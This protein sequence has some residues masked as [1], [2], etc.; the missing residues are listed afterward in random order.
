ML[1]TAVQQLAAALRPSARPLSPSG[2]DR[3]EVV[4]HSD[5]VEP[6]SRA[7]PGPSLVHHS[8][9]SSSELTA[10][11]NASEA[12]FPELPAHCLPSCRTLTS[13]GSTP[14]ARAKRAWIAGQWA[15]LVLADHLPT[16][17]LSAKLSASIRPRVYIVL[18]CARLSGPARF[19]SGRDFK[20]AVG[21]LEEFTTLCHAFAS[22]CEAE[23]YCEAA[24]VPLPPESP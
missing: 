11:Y 21:S 5:P 6:G 15:R 20:R 13:A 3:W 23:V 12:S 24:G 16:P 22:L 14:E 1:A 18:R 17:R 8:S 9:L 4:D 10:R 7:A 2:S 19:S